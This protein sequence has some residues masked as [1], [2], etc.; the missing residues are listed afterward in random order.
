MGRITHFIENWLWVSQ[1]KKM[2][3]HLEDEE[4]DEEEKEMNK[5]WNLLG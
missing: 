4:Q 5:K 3:E 1:I 2:I